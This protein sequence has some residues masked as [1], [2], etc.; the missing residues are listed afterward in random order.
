MDPTQTPVVR[1]GDASEPFVGLLGRTIERDLDRERTP[2]HQAISD[3]GRDKR[4]VGE[5]S[6]EEALLLGIGI[7]VKEIFPGED[8]S[9]CVENPQATY[10]RNLVQEVAMLVVAQLTASGLY[11][12]HRKIVIAVGALEGAPAS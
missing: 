5:Q 9:P 6:D 11:I 10:I 8:L 4:T 12:T 1:P 3:P 2:F 7:N